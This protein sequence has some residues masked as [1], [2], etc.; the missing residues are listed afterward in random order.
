VDSVTIDLEK[1]LGESALRRREVEDRDTPW[2]RAI[3]MRLRAERKARERAEHAR[4]VALLGDKREGSDGV[5]PDGGRISDLGPRI[6][7][8]RGEVVAATEREGLDAGADRPTTRRVK[9]ARRVWTPDVLLASG[10]ITLAH[11]NAAFTLESEWQLGIEGAREAHNRLLR[12]SRAGA[13]ADGFNDARVYAI[14]RCR[15]V[16]RVLGAVRWPVVSWAVL[17]TG[18]LSGYA[19]V[20]GW[21]LPGDE[22]D[23]KKAGRL[24]VSALD[25]LVAIY[26]SPDQFIWRDRLEAEEVAAEGAA[27][28]RGP[29]ARERIEPL[30]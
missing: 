17:S 4:A 6:R 27:S 8:D 22:P 2:E 3:R 5:S 13:G 26:D 18:S 9:R 30:F 29:K 28:K 10:T 23:H 20:R 24:L 12:M 11:H 25:D 14:S 1:L 19:R 16:E 15:A 21:V 7:R